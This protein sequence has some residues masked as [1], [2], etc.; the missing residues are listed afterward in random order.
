M[1]ARVVAVAVV[2]AAAAAPAA[3][4]AGWTR[5]TKPDGSSAEPV[6]LARSADGGLHVASRL[7]ARAAFQ[8]PS[9]ATAFAYRR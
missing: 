7:T 4:A 5:V 2:T 1:K 8:I 9:V 6:E 3:Q